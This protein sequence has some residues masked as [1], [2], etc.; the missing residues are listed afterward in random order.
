MNDGRPGIGHPPHANPT[1]APVMRPGVPS[2]GIALRPHPVIS[3]PPSP[4][5]PLAMPD[6]PLEL[7]EDEKAAAT[8]T[9]EAPKSKI[10]GITAANSLAQHTYKRA[11][12][13]NKCGA[14]RMRT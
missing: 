9:V 11:T 2:A 13:V 10:H 5:R 3:P 6:E 1:V 12:N 8:T 4:T 7:V 14:V